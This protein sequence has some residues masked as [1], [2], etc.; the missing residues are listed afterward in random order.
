MSLGGIGRRSLLGAAGGLALGGQAALAQGAAYPD[1]PVRVIIPFPPG[2]PM[3]MVARMLEQSLPPRFGRQPL[4]VENRSGGGG[5]IAMEA[6]MRA[7]PDGHTMII[8]TPG[9]GAVLLSLV[10]RIAYHTPR[11]FAAVTTMFESPST[12]VVRANSPLRSF[13]D[14]LAAARRDPGRLN[15]ATTGIGGTP[16]LAV[17]LVKMRTGINVTHVPYR[18]AGP[19]QTALLSGEV[20]FAFLDLSGQLAQIRGGTLRAMAVAAAERHP[21]APDV[22]T[23]AE[24]G[25]P[26]VQVASW[27]M[28]LVPAAT[29]RDRIAALYTAITGILNETEARQRFTGLG[30]LVRGTSPEATQAFLANEVTKWA[31]VIRVANIRLE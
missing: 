12:L 19:A 28:V 3:D 25:V 14:V 17:E 24:L 2:G 10:P 23:L 18:G 13:A 9:P 31:E 30:F 20:D 8:T 6:A 29:P 22:P 4:V 5:T 11:D 7:A 26:D 1:R 16:H 15:F 21:A 27:Y